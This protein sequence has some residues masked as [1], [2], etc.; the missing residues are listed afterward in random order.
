MSNGVDSDI[1]GSPDLCFEGVRVVTDKG[2][3]ETGR[4]VIH[5]GQTETTGTIFQV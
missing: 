3:R 1:T 2:L 5:R 4:S